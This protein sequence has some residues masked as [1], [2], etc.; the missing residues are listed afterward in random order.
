MR[1]IRIVATCLAAHSS[2][3]I[4]ALVILHPPLSVAALDL[5]MIAASGWAAAGVSN[6]L[7][8]RF[9]SFLCWG[10]LLH[11]LRRFS[12]LRYL[13]RTSRRLKKIRTSS[14]G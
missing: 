4:R 11:C 8:W 12:K 13:Q 14:F 3:D 10:A 9:P 5:M 7:I 1:N 6:R 2:F